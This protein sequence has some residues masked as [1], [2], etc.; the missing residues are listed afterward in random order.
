VR[1]ADALSGQHGMMNN[2][3]TCSCGK[4]CAVRDSIAIFIGR[5]LAKIAAAKKGNFSK[6]F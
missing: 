4:G 5:A 1:A 6:G 3:K 2:A